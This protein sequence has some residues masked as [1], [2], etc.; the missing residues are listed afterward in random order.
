VQQLGLEES[1]ISRYAVGAPV[2]QMFNYALR[3]RKDVELAS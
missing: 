3:T 1:A 2:R